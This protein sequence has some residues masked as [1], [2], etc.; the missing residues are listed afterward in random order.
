MRKKGI[1]PV[2]RA[3]EKVHKLQHIL[4]ITHLP[5]SGNT[6]DILSNNGAALVL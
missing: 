2:S 3:L 6:G 1:A 4:S 5:S